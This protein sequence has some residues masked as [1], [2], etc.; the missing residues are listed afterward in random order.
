[1]GKSHNHHIGSLTCT[2]LEHILTIIIVIMLTHWHRSRLWHQIQWSALVQVMASCL[3]VAKPSPYLYWLPDGH[4]KINWDHGEIWIK[5][6]KKKISRTCIWKFRLQNGRH[7]V[8]ALVSQCPSP[9]LGIHVC[10]ER[11]CSCYLDI[12]V[13]WWWGALK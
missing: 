6:K 2:R 11:T 13:S 8:E 7:M 4:L 5:M 3:W 10:V 12:G 1:M 9:T